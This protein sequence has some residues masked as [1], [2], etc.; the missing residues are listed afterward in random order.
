MN[1]RSRRA[2]GNSGGASGSGKTP[3]GKA[4]RASVSDMLLGL[5]GQRAAP[6]TDVL[7]AAPLA[8]DPIKKM[9]AAERQ[10]RELVQ[11]FERQ[12]QA[13]AAHP[14]SLPLLQSVGRLAQRLNRK[15][16]ALAAYR[17]WLALAPENPEAQHMVA[18]LSGQAP[19]RAGD[20]FVTEL[21]DAFADTFDRTLTH[22]LEYRAPALVASLAR[23]LLAGRTAA[24]AADLG[25][26]T[27]LLGPDA[28]PLAQV[29]HGVDLS[30]RML[31]KAR[32]R[33]LYDHLHHGEII[34]WLTARPRQFD[35]LLA[36][37]VLSYFGALGPVF[38][39]IG[40]AL[41]P[42][43]ILVATVEAGAGSGYA[44]GN[45]GRY[46]HGAPYLEAEARKAGLS[47]A[48]IEPGDLRQE[49][50]KPVAGLIFALRLA[51]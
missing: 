39:A 2:A 40:G 9:L 3:T 16:E 5:A 46:S 25:C 36:A 31:E 33:K 20:R 24:M 32:A 21:F 41:Q 19:E 23:R 50:G 22:W 48:A 34:G 1:R 14:D 51:S 35:L 37:D 18:A 30:P 29:L 7:A 15:P 43:G 11:E 47:V 42:D 12:Q 13:L 44:A 4:P 28:R 49:D 17:R 38:T 10:Q 8:D 27:G 26:G 45:N 6:L